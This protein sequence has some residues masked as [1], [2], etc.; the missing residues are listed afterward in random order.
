MTQPERQA[1]L[2]R[3]KE[4]RGYQVNEHNANTVVSSNTAPTSS[5]PASVAGTPIAMTISYSNAVNSGANPSV[6]SNHW[7]TPSVISH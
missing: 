3:L 6:V 2:A 7:P 1:E 5:L 4:A